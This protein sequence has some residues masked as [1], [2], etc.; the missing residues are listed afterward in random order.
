[1]GLCIGVL[2]AGQLGR[3]LALAGYPLG[4]RFVFLDPT[5]ASPAS[6][7]GE[8]L[9]ADYDDREALANL[10]ACDVITYEFE[11]VPVEAAEAF[12]ES[13]PVYPP[14]GALR[15]AQDRLFEKERFRA[16]GIPTADFLPV[17]S[18]A[19]LTDAA[20]QLGFPCVLKTRRF[21][22]DGKGQA[23]LRSAEDL[24]SAWDS[25][26]SAPLILERFI[27]FDRELS[28]L[29]VR[30]RDGTTLFYPLVENVHREGILRTTRAPA[31]NVRDELRFQA[32]EYCQNLLDDLNYVGVITLELF[33]RGQ[34]L[35]AN[36]MAPR[37]HNSGHFSIEGART[38]QFENHLRAV[39]GLP[40]GSTEVH[41]PCCMLN[42][43]GALPDRAAV[44]EVPGAHLH[45]YGKKPRPG[46]KVGHIT[47]T[48]ADRDQ[49]EKRV[50]RLSGLP[51][52][53]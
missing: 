32:E 39:L 6:E 37:V 8:Q 14:P 26:G 30:A 4:L 18:R 51:G 44:L 40:L 29:G 22:Y 15:V 27:E 7:L 47:V 24:N 5:P 12:S 2:G 49:L 16:L 25:L 48:G 52:T 53:G 11:S 45:I 50:A 33:Q 20:L 31:P 9:V 13:V 28:I 19:A 46:R 35:Y 41:E 3:M 17:D 10:S 43:V 34:E 42:L 1:M 38:S 23:V 36:E 21:G